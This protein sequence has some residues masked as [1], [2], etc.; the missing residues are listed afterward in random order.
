MGSGVRPVSRPEH[1]TDPAFVAVRPEEMPPRERLVS[2]VDEEPSGFDRPTPLMPPPPDS[3]SMV[4]DRGTLVRMDGASAGE[5][6]VVPREGSR[7]GRSRDAE[8]QIDDDSVSRLHALIHHVPGTGFVVEDLGSRNGTTINGGR[9]NGRRELSD[10]DVI[11][12]GPRASL[13]FSLVDERQA[14]FLKH[15]Y[16]SSTCDMLTGAFNRRHFD[17]R[18]RVELSYATRHATELGLVI[19]DLDHFKQVNDT[20][21]HLAGDAVLK[22][23]A[24]IVTARLRVEDVF[25]RYGGEEFVV[26]LRGVDLAGTARAAE[27]LRGAIAGARPI[28]D[29]R[30]IP[31]TISAGVTVLSEHAEAT[32]EAL[33]AKADRR[34]YAAKNAG[35]NRVVATG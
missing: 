3:R 35:R 23:V 17:E 15:L 21:G 12:F 18:F 7:V 1:P 31:A 10:G 9:I 19:F 14:E 11:Q 13:R 2:L 32:A 27:R 6:I 30:M 24:A 22:H 8:L 33:L 26:L 25:A 4:R 28:H 5:A 16:V 29:G 34:L 20:H